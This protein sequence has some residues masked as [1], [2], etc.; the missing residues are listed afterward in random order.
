MCLSQCFP[1]FHSV[2]NLLAYTIIINEV[3]KES[4]V[5]SGLWASSHTGYVSIKGITKLISDPSLESQCM[6][7]QLLKRYEHTKICVSMLKNVK[8][9]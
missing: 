3:L 6:G 7:L 4:V 1:P 9:K 8:H 5:L 2:V